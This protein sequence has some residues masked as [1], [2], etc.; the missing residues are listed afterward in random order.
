MTNRSMRKQ[1]TEFWRLNRNII[2]FAGLSLLDG[3]RSFNQ[4]Q[5]FGWPRFVIYINITLGICSIFC[6]SVLLI[7]FLIVTSYTFPKFQFLSHPALGKL[8]TEEDQ[9]VRLTTGKK[10]CSTNC[11]FYNFVDPSTLLFIPC[12]F[13]S[14]WFC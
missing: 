14:T 13:L 4:Y 6:P 8:L 1:V 10:P 2:G 11:G 7:L 9:K 5:T 12:R 3:M